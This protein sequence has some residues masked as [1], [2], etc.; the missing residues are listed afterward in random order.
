MAIF[1][2]GVGTDID[3]VLRICQEVN[4]P[5][6]IRMLRG[7]IPRLFDPSQPTELNNG[8]L[9]KE[10]TDIALFSSSICTE[11]AMRATH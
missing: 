5:L 8:R 2:C 10:G 1:D 11:E 7:E 6:Y 4:R 9:I 3:A